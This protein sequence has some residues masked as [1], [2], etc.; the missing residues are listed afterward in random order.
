MYTIPPIKKGLS[1]NLDAFLTIG[2]LLMTMTS[3]VLLYSAGG[4]EL[5]YIKK[6]FI[7]ACIAFAALI[8]IAQIPVQFIHRI[9]PFCYFLGVLALIFVL[10]SGHAGKGAQRWLNLGFIT[11]Q[12]SEFM[13]ILLP[14]MLA[15]WLDKTINA[16]PSY[17]AWIGFAIISAIPLS[18]VILQPDLGTS[19]MIAT[20]AIFIIVL[21]GISWKILFAAGSVAIASLPLLWINMHAY[22]KSRVLTF[23]DPAKDPLGAGYQTI[24]SQIAISTGRLEGKGWL[25]GTQSQLNFVPEQHTDFIFSIL[26]EE[27]GFLGVIAL[28]ALLFAILLRGLSIAYQSENTF[29][30]LLSATLIA[31][32]FLNCIVNIAM[33]VGLLPIVGLPLPFIS[34]G[35]SSLLTHAIGFGILMSCCKTKLYWLRK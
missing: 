29:T 12:P 28:F 6:Q 13:K 5:V 26:A 21:S 24:Q 22:Q 31:G 4:G 33:V 14:L 9:V 23:L 15:W 16:S 20:T 10:T 34:Y 17:F 27:F 19:I 11:I 1:I 3:L 2:F 30:R 32:F 18:L 7:N 25:N 35:G 8:F